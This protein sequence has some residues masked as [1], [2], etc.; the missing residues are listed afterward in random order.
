MRQKLRTLGKIAG[1]I[2]CTIVGLCIAGYGVDTLTRTTK[3]YYVPDTYRD[4]KENEEQ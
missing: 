3:K 1:S 2:C 4:T